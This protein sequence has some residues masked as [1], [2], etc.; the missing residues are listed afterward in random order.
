M[1]K[2]RTDRVLYAGCSFVF[3]GQGSPVHLTVGFISFCCRLFESIVELVGELV[4]F[5]A[6]SFTHHL[7]NSPHGAPGWNYRG[8]RE[9]M[10]PREDQHIFFTPHI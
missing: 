3:V 10:K 6:V 9:D 7:S 5:P 2:E 8:G 1:R 4:V